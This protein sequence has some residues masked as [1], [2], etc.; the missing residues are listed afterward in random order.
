MTHRSLPDPFIEDQAIRRNF[1]ELNSRGNSGIDLVKDYNA[2]PTG[3]IDTAPILQAANDDIKAGTLPGQIINVPAG[4]FLLNS[5]A[6]L[7][8]NVTLQGAGTY[9]TVFKLG[10]ASS[11]LKIGDMTDGDTRGGWCG[12]FSIDMND[13]GA[14]PALRIE[15]VNRLFMDIRVFNPGTN[16]VGALYDTAQNCTTVNLALEAVD[17]AVTGTKGLD[18]DRGASGLRFYN[19]ITDRWSSSAV[20]IHQSAA[21]QSPVSQPQPTNISFYGGMV[22]RGPTTALLFNIRDGRQILVQGV[23]MSLGVGD[24]PQA[25]YDINQIRE[26]VTTAGAITLDITFRDCAVQGGINTTAA[27]DENEATAFDIGDGSGDTDLYVT[28]ERCRFKN[29]LNIFDADASAQFRDIEN[30]SGSYTNWYTSGSGLGNYEIVASASTITLDTFSPVVS[31]SGTTTIGTINL[32]PSAQM[33]HIAYLHFL[34]SLTVTHSGGNILLAGAGD[35]SATAN[36]V[37]TLQYVD[38]N[39]HEISRTVK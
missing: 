39:W 27:P 37:L 2:D 24:D 23:A 3:V 20:V 29:I 1:E 16:G 18:I 11:G 5:V 15:S 38:G 35:F 12:A 17:E 25:T 19:L 4:T 30:L 34:G 31:V 22:E 36:D 9:A 32:T 33:G 10:N 14:N 13:F 6:D 28:I 26:S 7:D 8:D 21:T